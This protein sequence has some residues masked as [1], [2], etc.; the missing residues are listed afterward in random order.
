MRP[1]KNHYFCP[2]CMD[3][4]M[5]FE[6]EKEAYSFIEYES[7]IILEEKGYC[8]IRAYKCPIC[9]CWHLTS[10]LLAE[11]DC[12]ECC[13]DK[14]EM[15]NIRRLLGLVVRNMNTIALNLSRKVKTFSR[16]LK[17]KVV[18]WDAASLLA[19]EVI[20]IFEKVWITPYR[21]VY[22]VRK[23]LY[24]F[25]ELCKLYIWRKNQNLAA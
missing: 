11:D 13:V 15:E 24:E 10:E 20:E 5:R 22:D 19:K 17:R 6:T 7:D 3:Y 9:G 23:Q 2:D 1:T 12:Y 21:Y 14:E 16:M 8:P 4:K 25:D 18:D